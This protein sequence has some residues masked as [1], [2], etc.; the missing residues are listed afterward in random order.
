MGI[1]F[2]FNRIVIG[3]FVVYA[4]Q[5]APRLEDTAKVRIQKGLDELSNPI[6]LLS[7]R[8][9]LFS[10]KQRLSVQLHPTLSTALWNDEWRIMNFELRMKN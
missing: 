1:L 6:Q 5:R 7:K 4:R 10:P 8:I 2:M 9:H 3:A